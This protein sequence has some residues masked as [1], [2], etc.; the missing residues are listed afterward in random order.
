[1]QGPHWKRGREK[2]RGWD[3]N[4][5]RNW[6]FYLILWGVG[7]IISLSFSWLWWW[8]GSQDTLI[9]LPLHTS[10]C[11]IPTLQYWAREWPDCSYIQTVAS[12]W[13]GNTCMLEFVHGHICSKK[14][15]VFW[16]HSS[17]KTVSFEELMM[18]KDKYQSMFLDQMEAIVLNILQL[19]FTTWAVLAI[20]LSWVMWH[21]KT[22]YLS[23]NIW[24]VSNTMYIKK[25]NYSS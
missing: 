19:F 13:W 12:I 6:Q 4:G 3:G 24:W 14:R 11:D 21:I 22:N 10:T 2:V 1:M 18:S 20:S 17:V 7:V 16:E 23:K 8:C 5:V 25:Y 9:F 15:T